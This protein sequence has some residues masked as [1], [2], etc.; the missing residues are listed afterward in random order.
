MEGLYYSKEE[1]ENT[2][3]HLLRFYENEYVIYKC[4]VGDAPAYISKELRSFVMEG[5]MVKAQ[6]EYTF[7]GA[8]QTDGTSLKFT[9]ENE[10][11]DPSDSWV[12]KDRLKFNG[13]VIHESELELTFLSERTKTETTR[14]YLKTSEEQLIKEL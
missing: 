1:G 14:S 3:F 2:K 9:V 11:M 12:Q 7:C 8:Y 5:M 13:K 4:V 6:P 10:I